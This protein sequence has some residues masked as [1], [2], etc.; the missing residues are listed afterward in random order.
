[1]T[2]GTPKP[3][4]TPSA[5]LSLNDSAL[6]EPEELGEFVGCDGEVDVDVADVL[7]VCVSVEGSPDVVEV[8]LVVCEVSEEVEVEV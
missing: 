6:L 3:S 1:M 7:L 4:P 5:I 2:P 8:V